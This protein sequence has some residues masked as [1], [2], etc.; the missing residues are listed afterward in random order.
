[1]NVLARVSCAIEVRLLRRLQGCSVAFYPAGVCS[2]R[3]RDCGRGCMYV[4][5]GGTSVGGDF[6]VTIHF[7]GFSRVCELDKLYIMRYHYKNDT[8]KANFK[9][10]CY[11]QLPCS[12]V[13]FHRL[14][15]PMESSQKCSQP[16]A[17]THLILGQN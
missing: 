5:E 10:L 8:F 9:L 7:V 2:D 11:A 16:Q 15:G 4:L 12:A 3:R 1:M 17:D 6:P 13:F 14:P